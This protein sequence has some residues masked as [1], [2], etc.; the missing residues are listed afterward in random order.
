[1]KIGGEFLLQSRESCGK[2]KTNRRRIACP[3]CGKGTVIW[4]LPS[5]AVKDLPVKCKL[6]GKESVLN[7]SCVPV[8]DVPVP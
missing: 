3:A 1:M 2:I 8:P 5:S 6:C 7:I 4:M